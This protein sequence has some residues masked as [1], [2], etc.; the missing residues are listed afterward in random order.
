MALK[1][2]K[3]RRYYNLLQSDINLIFMI[4]RTLDCLLQ[5]VARTLFG[6]VKNH[7]TL[8]CHQL[9]KNEEKKTFVLIQIWM[10]FMMKFLSLRGE[11]ERKYYAIKVFSNMTSY[12]DNLLLE[13][14]EKLPPA[15][16]RFSHN[17]ISSLGSFRSLRW[18]NLRFPFSSEW[19]RFTVR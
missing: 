3:S 19:E 4:R 11:R 16:A 7:V 15:G 12:V 5:V 13:W 9:L 17:E 14:G 8:K 18:K 2:N 10:D 6:V 1:G